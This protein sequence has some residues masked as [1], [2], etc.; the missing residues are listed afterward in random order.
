MLTGL[1]INMNNQIAVIEFW[2]RSID[3]W[4]FASNRLFSSE[5]KAKEHLRMNGYKQLD[6]MI[7]FNGTLRAIITERT[8]E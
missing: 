2:R 8:V 3:R 1:E 4:E 7:Y 5:L 6:E